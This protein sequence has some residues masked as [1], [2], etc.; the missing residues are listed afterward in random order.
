MK[1]R[2][3]ILHM[4]DMIGTVINNTNERTC[5]IL[6]IEY[7]LQLAD[8]NNKLSNTIHRLNQL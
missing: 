2:N 6:T 5:T 3:I 8:N 1:R 7:A 4:N